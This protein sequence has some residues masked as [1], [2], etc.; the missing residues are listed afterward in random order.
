MCITVKKSALIDF[1]PSVRNVPFASL[2][3]D[4]IT[5]DMPSLW[6]QIK[7]CETGRRSRPPLIVV[8]MHF[9]VTDD[10]LQASCEVS[11]QRCC[12]SLSLSLIQEGHTSLSLQIPAILVCRCHRGGV[13]WR[14]PT[15]WRGT[16]TSSSNPRS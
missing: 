11:R 1:G 13:S 3:S 14:S 5:P 2:W 10:S 16:V 9:D 4:Y 12:S 15:I 6:K 7:K 8:L